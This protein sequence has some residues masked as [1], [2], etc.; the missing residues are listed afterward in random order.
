MLKQL[1]SQITS[2][3]R[4]KPEKKAAPKAE[5][6]AVSDSVV[7]DSPQPPQTPKPPIKR[8]V[9]G[10]AKQYP[11]YDAYVERMR[12][13]EAKH[14]G[15]ARMVEIGK[16]VQGR[17][18]QSLC[19]G[20][21]P[22]GV[23]ISALLHAREWATGE[24]TLEACET[25]LKER[26]ELLEKLTIHAIPV[27]NPDGYELSRGVLGNQRGNVNGVDIN[28][29]MPTDNWGPN[30]NT[31]KAH[32]DEYGGYGD[33]PL[34]EPESKA[35]AGVV[36]KDGMKG[37]MDI[38]S[39]GELLL[40]PEN[41]RPKEYDQLIDSLHSVQ[42]T[43]YKRLNVQEFQPINGSLGDFCEANG[44]IAVGVELG[45]KFKPVDEERE[46]TLKEGHDL[47]MAFLD[48]MAKDQ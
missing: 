10:A 41:S 38:H 43:P 26:P 5:S 42:E 24:P 44:V 35:L 32:C 39:H 22:V 37:W 20:H 45:K 13:L 9:Y 14:P 23:G 27:A 29:N 6:T 12:Q 11:D 7:L 25:V 16:S 31:P 40:V 28:R 3:F 8:Q 4:G 47:T 21:G 34:S 2:L 1:G 33:A 17:A 18:I 15:M 46:Q 19:I 30:E 36:Q 48:H